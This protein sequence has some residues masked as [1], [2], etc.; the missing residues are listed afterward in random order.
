MESG[1]TETVNNHQILI[2][3][4]ELKHLVI[5]GRLQDVDVKQKRVASEFY[6]F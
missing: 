6:V 3:G 2:V 4:N 1:V 5:V